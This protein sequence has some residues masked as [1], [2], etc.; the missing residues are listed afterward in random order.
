MFFSQKISENKK[1]N[2][3]LLVAKELVLDI[4]LTPLTS[5]IGEVVNTGFD[6]AFA[7]VITMHLM[8]TAPCKDLLQIYDKGKISQFLRERVLAMLEEARGNCQ[9]EEKSLSSSN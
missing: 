2:E 1:I 7:Q 6:A 3:I 8:T 4:K 9:K 5:K